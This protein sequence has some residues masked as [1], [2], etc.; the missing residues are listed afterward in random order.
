MPR[1]NDAD[2]RAIRAWMRSGFDAVK[3]ELTSRPQLAYPKTL[4]MFWVRPQIKGFLGTSGRGAWACQD[5]HYRADNSFQAMGGFWINGVANTQL[6]PEQHLRGGP[7]F[8]RQAYAALVALFPAAYPE[9]TIADLPL[10]GTYKSSL[11]GPGPGLT[12]GHAG[13]MAAIRAMNP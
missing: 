12:G 4:C 7:P 8:H 10:Y 13:A 11:A 2:F 6:N 9:A 1:F 3:C 5:L